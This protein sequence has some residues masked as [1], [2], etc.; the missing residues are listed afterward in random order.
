[1][2]IILYIF[3]CSIVMTVV[4]SSFFLL[5]LFGQIFFW[6]DLNFFNKKKKESLY[7]SGIYRIVAVGNIVTLGFCGLLLKKAPS[8]AND[9][10][11]ACQQP[12]GKWP[13]NRRIGVLFLPFMLLWNRKIKQ[14]MWVFFQ[15]DIE[16]KPS[17][18][19]DQRGNLQFT[20]YMQ[21]RWYLTF[22]YFTLFYSLVLQYK[23]KKM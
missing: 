17:V 22:W 4:S 21:I 19:F 20:I 23:L 11:M 2:E 3:T 18:T 7:A 8:L 14:M 5:C 10:W 12:L 1:M 13:E 9:W 6:H 15:Y 16:A